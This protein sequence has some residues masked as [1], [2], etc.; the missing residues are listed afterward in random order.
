MTGTTETRTNKLDRAGK[1]RIITVLGSM[2]LFGAMLFI[3]AGRLGWIEAWVFLAISLGGVIAN[4][5]W[6]MRNNP[7]MLNERGRIGK[8]A[9]GWD[10]V[11]GLVYT[12]FLFAIYL[13]GGLDK[14]FGWSAAPLWVEIL[15]GAAYALSMALNFWVMKSNAFLSTFVRIQEDRGHTTV[16]G[17]PYR[18][19]RHPMYVGILL[20]SFGMPFLLGSWIAL[21]PGVLNIA[22]FFV[23][24]ALEDRTLQEEL[25]GYKEY[26]QQT[27]YRL[28]PGIW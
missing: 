27:R 24:T 1:G 22:L 21:I 15:G 26:T 28:I 25:P 12:V 2:L 3:A 13:L 9:K 18:F 4:G 7:E 5:L 17:G 19:V 8:N 20:M 6:S 14:R 11:I 16:T 10:K 23:R